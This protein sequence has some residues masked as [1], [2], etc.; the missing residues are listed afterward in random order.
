MDKGKTPRFLNSLFFNKSMDI[1]AHS[2]KTPGNLGALA[3]AM[4]NFNFSSLVLWNPKC[5]HLAKEALD[6]ACFAK[7]ILEN[8][9]V[10]EDLH[11]DTL[12]GTT[13]IIGSDYNMRRNTI[14]PEELATM[15]LHGTVGLIIG[16]EGDGLTNEEL[17][18]C[19]ILITIPTFP[20]SR[21]MNVS[22]AATVIMYELFKQSGKEKLGENIEYA[23]RIEKDHL[24]QLIETKMKDMRFNNEHQ[25]ETQL[26][27]WKKLIGKSNLTKREAMVLFGF[28]KNI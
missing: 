14:S 16:Q 13:S 18:Q 1:I 24:M 21:V 5:H 11:Y 12:I 17:D 25:Q 3:R 15:E 10:V 26:I 22:H 6:R 8:A 27:V 23:T 2:W 4:H 7:D 20:E 9:S 28:V 19:D